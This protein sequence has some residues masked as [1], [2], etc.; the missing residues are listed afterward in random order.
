MK[1]KLLSNA[2]KS[3]IGISAAVLVLPVAAQNGKTD[4]KKTVSLEEVVVT[5]SRISRAGFDTLQPATTIGKDLFDRNAFTNVADALAGLPSMVSSGTSLAESDANNVGQS[6]A[7]LYGLGSQRTLTLVNG[8]RA[9]SAN[10]PTAFGASGGLQVDLNSIPTA[11]IDRV[12]VVSVGGAPI[13]GSDAIAGTINVILKDDFEGLEAD[14][15]GGG[16][17][18]KMT[19]LTTKLVLLGVPTF[20]MVAAML[21]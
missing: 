16:P 20:P 3:V 12:E 21:C 9:V 5:G 10:A 11:L 1:K 17:M 2:I 7:D 14:F 19:P 15:S 8:R 6:F 4:D 13:Y 18:G